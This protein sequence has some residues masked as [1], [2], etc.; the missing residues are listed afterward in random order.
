MQKVIDNHIF[1]NE[2]AKDYDSMI[3]FE[4]SVNKK[5]K[6]LKSFIHSETRNAADIGC[7]TGADSIS[8]ASSGLK[9]TAFDPSIEMLK[10]A[11]INAGNFNV[12]IELQN[13]SATTIPNGFNN[14]F[15]LIVSLG[16]TFANIPEK[17]FS[18]SL[19]RC[20][21]SRVFAAKA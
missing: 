17:N 7:G 3:S 4:S 10:R 16:N 9:V 6:L 12:K 13:F 1:Y 14:S 21:E 18:N 8:L 11:G 2:L 20:F 5:I 15:D 19:K